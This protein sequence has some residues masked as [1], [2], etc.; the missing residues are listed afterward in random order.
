MRHDLDLSY[1]SRALRALEDE[2]SCREHLAARHH[3][4]DIRQLP[5]APARLMIVVDE[6][7]MLNE[8][9]PGYMG[10]TASRGLARSFA[11]HA[12]GGVHAES[13]GGDQRLD[14][15]Q[16]ES[17]HMSSSPGCPCNPMR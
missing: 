9:L 4:S 8:Q 10:Q 11:W 1:A 3:V 16:Y 6:F 7:H 5:D 2:L 13:D 15:G 14:E 17:A 12:S